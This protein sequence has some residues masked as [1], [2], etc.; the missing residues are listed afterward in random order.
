MVICMNPYGVIEPN[1]PF[2]CWIPPEIGSL[3]L[4]MEATIVARPSFIGIGAVVR[5]SFGMVCDAMARR[6]LGNFV[7]F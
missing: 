1:P 2:A 4:N 3:K 7:P 6:F 5:N